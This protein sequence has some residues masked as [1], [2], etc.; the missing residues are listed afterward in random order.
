MEHFKF[1]YSVSAGVVLQYMI[2]A[3]FAIKKWTSIQLGNLF[4]TSFMS[5]NSYS[6]FGL[7][8]SNN[9]VSKFTREEKGE[10]WLSEGLLRFQWRYMAFLIS[11]CS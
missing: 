7:T 1:M 5:Y 2:S 4:L 6:R 9:V 8:F 3:S 11:F 10:T